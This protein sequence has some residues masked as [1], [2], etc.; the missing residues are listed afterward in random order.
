MERESKGLSL[1]TLRSSAQGAQRNM[2]TVFLVHRK[3]N[4]I[5]GKRVCWEESVRYWIE[6]GNVETLKGFVQI[7]H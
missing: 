3:G 1:K 6:Q 7:S 2:E 5:I 4:R